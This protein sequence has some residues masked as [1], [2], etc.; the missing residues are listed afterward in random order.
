MHGIVACHAVC[1]DNILHQT[2][3]A[4]MSIGNMVGF[5][6]HKILEIIHV[7]SVF[8]GFPDLPFSF[9]VQIREL[10]V[11]A[12]FERDGYLPRRR[13]IIPLHILC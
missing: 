1:N 11:R 2:L 8:V 7:Q 10:E 3:N 5:N 4:S 9:K 12:V 13:T 6:T